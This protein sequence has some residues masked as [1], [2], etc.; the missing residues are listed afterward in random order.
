MHKPMVK[1]KKSAFL[2]SKYHRSGVPKPGYMY[3]QGLNFSRAEVESR[4]GALRPTRDETLKCRDRDE[5]R[6]FTKLFWFKPGFWIHSR[7]SESHVFFWSRN[8]ISF[9][10]MLKPE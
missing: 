6:D 9:L 7:K 8:Q 4:H 2:A 10:N 5:T 3:L 1:Q